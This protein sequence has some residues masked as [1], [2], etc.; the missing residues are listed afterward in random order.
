MASVIDCCASHCT[1]S[2]YSSQ[3]HTDDG[4]HS[5]DRLYKWKVLKSM[6]LYDVL[7]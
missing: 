5:T 1:S 2:Q 7:K 6:D 3:V 4:S